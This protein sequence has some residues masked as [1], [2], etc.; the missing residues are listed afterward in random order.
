MQG[1]QKC[2]NDFE[3]PSQNSC[4][5]LKNPTLILLWAQDISDLLDLMTSNEAR[6]RL[7]KKLWGLIL[8]KWV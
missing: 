3:I 7:D 2:K 4:F 5:G 6:L 1:L 8:S